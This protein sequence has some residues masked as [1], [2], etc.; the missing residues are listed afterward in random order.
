MNGIRAE[1][2]KYKKRRIYML[3]IP[4]LIIPILLAL[5][6]IFLTDPYAAEEQS[7]LYWASIAV[8]MNSMMYVVPIIFSYASGLNLSEEIE[9]RFFGVLSQRCDKVSVYRTK[10]L[11]AM[12]IAIRFFLIELAGCTIIYYVTYFLGGVDLTGKI[13]GQ[14]YNIEA[15][16]FIV[17]MFLFYCILIP[18]A[19]SG[20]STYVTDK[21]K[22][23]ISFVI[24]IFVGRIIPGNDVSNHIVPWNILKEF[25]QI[26]T[27]AGGNN[28]GQ[29]LL[30]IGNSLLVTL[31]I[32]VTCYW[33]GRNR[34]RRINL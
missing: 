18:M 14:G 10:M 22:L 27:G 17:E 28:L 33:L 30:S 5:N 1:L 24:V 31:V 20:I 16:A 19:I 6:S 34:I 26:E 11:A 12:I 3:S 15:L 32:G 9:N 29:S 13:L 7:L 4:L 21:N 2:Y 23:I 25:S 8:F